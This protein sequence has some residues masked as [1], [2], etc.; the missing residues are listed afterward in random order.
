MAK[1]E[2]KIPAVGTVINKPEL[3]PLIESYGRELVTYAV[4]KVID[5]YRA[6]FQKEDT[7]GIPEIVSEVTAIIVNIA[8]P[9]F[10]PVINATGIVLHTNL[11][12]A[13]LGTSVL[14]DLTPIVSGYSNVEFNLKGGCRG[15]RNE[16]IAELLRYITGA[17]DAIVVNNNAAAIIL[18]LHTFARNKEVIISRGELIEIGGSFRIPEIMR[19]SGAKMVEV[20]T[21][22]KTRLTDYEKALTKK[23]ACIFKAHQSNFTMSGFIEEVPLKELTAFSTEQGLPFVYD[24]GSGL[25]RK[26]ANLP[27]QNEPD[28]R[29]VVASGIDLVTFSC[30]K[31]LGGPQGG[32]IAGKREL[33]EKCAKNPLMRAF[34]VGKLTISALIS[35]C[36]SYLSDETL[37]RNNPAFSM[38]KQDRKQ[39]SARADKLCAALSQYAIPAETIPGIA[40]VGGGTLPDLRL[41]SVAVTLV[42]P[43]REKRKRQAFAEEI[44]CKLLQREMPVVAVLREGNLVFEIYT[45]S[46]DNI[47]GIALAVK[48][49]LGK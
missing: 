4:R 48:E 12:R 10:K 46:D 27:L 5:T 31:L 26:P 3:Q 15:H 16:H 11:G 47:P 44:F 39:L 36:R 14:E 30:D 49:A 42:S 23:T 37:I 38:L 40:R 33:V 32:I 24:L 41:D 17:E 45:V 8:E 22:N 13:P 18:A 2:Q 21:T 6:S 20:G 7:L 35:A 29:S 9:S 34:R 43:S 1:K 25:L 19:A 28:V